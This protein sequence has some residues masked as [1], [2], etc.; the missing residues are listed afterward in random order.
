MILSITGGVDEIVWNSIAITYCFQL[1]ATYPFEPITNYL[2]R[3]FLGALSED[4]GW[5]V[6]FLFLPFPLLSARAERLKKEEKT[7]Q[8]LEKAK[9][10]LDAETTDLQ[11][12]IAE[13]LAQI[14]EMKTQLSKKEEEL[15]AVLARST[16]APSVQQI[17]N[18]SESYC[19]QRVTNTR[20]RLNTC[21]CASA[22]TTTAPHWQCM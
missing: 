12:Q 7:R 15:Q 4:L 3:A 21:V 8:E 18:C 2:I 13:L 5:C 16:F 10:K 14:D 17:L 1:Y 19:L 11:D 9:R 6:F 22:H 20:V